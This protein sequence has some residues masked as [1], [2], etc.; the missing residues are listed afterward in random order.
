MLSSF[1]STL[2]TTYGVQNAMCAMIS[3]RYPSGKVNV[4]KNIM[5]DTAMTISLLMMG[6][7]LTFSS[8]RRAFLPMAKM[9]IAAK[10]PM[11]VAIT[12]DTAAM[13]KVLPTASHSAGDF[14]EVN[15]EMYASKVNPS[16]KRK[17]ELLEKE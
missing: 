4:T 8:T 15:I 5:S 9:P 3:L 13:R 17:L 12:D 1:G 2:S 6:N 7:W 11:T 14:S 10:V 16:S